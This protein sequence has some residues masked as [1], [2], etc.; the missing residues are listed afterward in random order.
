MINGLKKKLEKAFKIPT[1]NI[2]YLGETVT[3]QFLSNV[4]NYVLLLLY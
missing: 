3:R 2:K 4:P 1:N